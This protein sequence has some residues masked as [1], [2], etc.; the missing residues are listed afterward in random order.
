MGN[1]YN[2]EENP[3]RDFLFQLMIMGYDI[4]DDEIRDTIDE[5]IVYMLES[6]GIGY[7]NI[8]YLDYDI[9]KVRGEH[10]KVVPENFITALWFSGIVPLNCDSA[11]E[12]NQFTYNGKLYTF[13]RKTK[14]ISWKIIRE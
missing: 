10:I 13:N 4:S 7:G 1:K 3:I 5:T 9:K 12:K 8:K 2:A 11:Y 6:M 14:K